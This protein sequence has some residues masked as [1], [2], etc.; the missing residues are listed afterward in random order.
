MRTLALVPVLGAITLLAGCSVSPFNVLSDDQRT[1]LR[2]GSSSYQQD[3]LADLVVDEVEYRQAMAD[4]HGCVG[5]AGA[6]PSEVVQTGNQLGFDYSIEAP[7]DTERVRIQTS[8][9]A[10]LPE[11]FDAIGRVWVSQ[12]TTLS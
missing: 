9:D 7:T 2:D 10:C 1:E 11:H 8:A 6:E 3:V 12:G 5:S 4:W